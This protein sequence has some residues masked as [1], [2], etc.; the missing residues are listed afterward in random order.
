M[1]IFLNLLTIQTH[2]TRTWCEPEASFGLDTTSCSCHKWEWKVSFATEH[3]LFALRMDLLRQRYFC[4]VYDCL[5][6]AE[7]SEGYWNLICKNSR[8][9][10]NI[11][12]LKWVIKTWTMLWHLSDAMTFE[13]DIELMKMLKHCSFLLS[14]IFILKCYSKSLLI[15]SLLK[16]KYFTSIQ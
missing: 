2:K 1:E 14:L 12:K 6:K 15:R 9:L 7:L 13:F 10:G 16:C 11:S 5:G 4:A 3:S 8:I